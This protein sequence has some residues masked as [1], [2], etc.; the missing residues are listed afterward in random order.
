[1]T[2]FLKRVSQSNL[3]GCFGCD[4]YKGMDCLLHA[5]SSHKKPVGCREDSFILTIVPRPPVG[6]RCRDLDG[7]IKV[8]GRDA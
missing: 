1:M 7:N 8:V 5:K 6:T 4:M 3:L 2:R